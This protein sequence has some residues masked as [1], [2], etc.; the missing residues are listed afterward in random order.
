M[1]L[2][3]SVPNCRVGPDDYECEVIKNGLVVTKHVPLHRFMETILI[4]GITPVFHE[5]LIKAAR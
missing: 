1:H 5:S 4:D 2:Y 3:F